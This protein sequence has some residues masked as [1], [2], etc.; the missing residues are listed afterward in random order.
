MNAKH[1]ITNAMVDGFDQTGG[2][3]FSC[4]PQT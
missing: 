1:I 3:L 4:I 2:L